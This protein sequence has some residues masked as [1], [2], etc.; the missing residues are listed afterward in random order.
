MNAKGPDNLTPRPGDAIMGTSGVPDPR[1]A[2][3]GLLSRVFLTA[4]IGKPHVGGVVSIP[5]VFCL[6]GPKLGKCFAHS[7][8]A[9]CYDD[10]ARLVL[11]VS[12]TGI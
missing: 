1:T 10:D 6:P 8:M 3:D 12:Q 9:M 5:A 4:A 7:D 11:T 2:I